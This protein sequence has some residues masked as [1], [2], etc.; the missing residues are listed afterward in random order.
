[1]KRG[2]AAVLGAVAVGLAL[3]WL[4]GRRQMRR[5]RHHLFSPRPLQRLAALGYLE[6]KP[7]AATLRLARDYLA[8]EPHPLLRR[9]ATRLIRRL[10]ANMR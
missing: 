2:G 3:G 5:H 6:G 9:R 7:S 4:T 10:E 8:W 1:M